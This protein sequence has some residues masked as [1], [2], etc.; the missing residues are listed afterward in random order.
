MSE[1]TPA[2]FIG[3]SSNLQCSR[4]VPF[5]QSKAAAGVALSGFEAVTEG[6]GAL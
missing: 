1:K 2:N 6:A 4:P 5:S 3:N